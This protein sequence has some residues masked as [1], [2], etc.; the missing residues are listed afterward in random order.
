MSPSSVEE[1]ISGESITEFDL[2]LRSFVWTPLNKNPFNSFLL[3]EMRL[4]KRRGRI[5]RSRVAWKRP[6]IVSVGTWLLLDSFVSWNFNKLENFVIYLE[7]IFI[8]EVF[9]TAPHGIYPWIYL[10]KFFFEVDRKFFTLTCPS[11]RILGLW[12]QAI[13]KVKGRTEVSVMCSK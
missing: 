8:D 5:A 7:R 2:K 13:S 4:R 1:K 11:S 3:L 6:T 12:E 9:F 10:L